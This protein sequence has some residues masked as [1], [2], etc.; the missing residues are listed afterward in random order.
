MYVRPHDILVIKFK[1]FLF[2]KQK[3]SNHMKQTWINWLLLLRN[4]YCSN[5]KK[6]NTLSSLKL[7]WIC[8]RLL[9]GTLWCLSETRFLL[10]YFHA[11]NTTVKSLTHWAVGLG[12][13]Q[14]GLWLWPVCG[15]QQFANTSFSVE[16]ALKWGRGLKH[17][18]CNITWSLSERFSHAE[19]SAHTHTLPASENLGSWLVASLPCQAMTSKAV[20][21]HEGTSWNW[22]RTGFWGSVTV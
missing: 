8:C 19:Q 12:H 14:T 21:L 4:K 9:G 7:T 11:K 6:K 5:K 17:A 10:R 18:Y 3:N 16:A 13:I 1:L 20:F 22:F 15:E 2:G